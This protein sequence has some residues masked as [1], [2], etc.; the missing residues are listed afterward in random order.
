MVATELAFSRMA[1]EE[2]QWT[3]FADYAADGAHMFVPEKV[4]AQE[5]LKG[6]ADPAQSI[7]W[8]PHRVWS[9]CDGTV[10]VTRGAWE[11]PGDT[12]GW[13]STVW[14]RVRDDRRG[15]YRF[16][17]DLSG[18]LE[19]PLPAR[20]MIG[21]D[22][23]RCGGAPGPAPAAPAAPEESGRSDDGTL[24]W[25]AGLDDAGRPQIRVWQWDGSEMAPADL[26]LGRGRIGL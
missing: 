15:E 23:A 22:I 13:Y 4:L 6:R 8:H 16:L 5:W 17:A 1:R 21:S 7:S 9:S 18:S 3:A 12:H 19:Q 10:A 26:S 20:D 2:G 24:Y 14:K 25:I 11:G